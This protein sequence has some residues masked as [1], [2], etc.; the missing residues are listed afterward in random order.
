MKLML[1]EQMRKIDQTAIK[2]YGVPSILLMEHAAYGVFKSIQ[3]MEN[4]QKIVILCGPGNN[5]GDGFALAR[6]LF[7]WSKYKIKI[8]ML[9][10]E[11]KLT[12][13][14][15]I[16]YNINRRIGNTIWHVSDENKTEIFKQ[17]LE[18]DL[19][20]D[21]LFGT[22][23]TRAVSGIYKEVIACANKAECRKVAVDIPSGIDGSTGKIRGI[24]FRADTTITFAAPKLGL[25]QYPAL[26]YIGELVVIDIGIPSAIIEETKTPYYTLELQ[27]LRQ[28]LGKRP[29]RSNKGTYGKVLIIGGQRGM[30]GAVT[31]AAK[32]ALKV[33]AGIVKAAVP[34]CIHNIMEEKLTE[35]MTVP[36]KDHDGHFAKEAAGEIKTLLPKYDVVVIG[37]GMGRS[38]ENIELIIEVLKSEKPC[39]LDADALYFLAELIDIAKIRRAPIIITPHPG[40]MSRIVG[41][42]IE[43]ILENPLEMARC[44]ATQNNIITVLKIERIV[45]AGISGDIYINR[46]GNPGM[47]KGGSG[48]LLTGV[49]AGLLGQG[50]EPIQAAGLGSYIH[51]YAGDLARDKKTEYSFLPMDLYEE[52]DS[53]F[54]L[55]LEG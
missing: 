25:C 27:E 14:G 47:A 8:F 10:S 52:L 49:I 24:A 44:F 29:T 2:E 48:D 1:P 39:I 55:L 21:A 51:A 22:G 32:A 35:V 5:G 54:K 41:K 34:E 33:G 11:E 31:L 38:R 43:E 50:L 19:I 28:L 13:D 17:L 9:A 18:A 30:S 36:L 46:K 23:L 3:E 6:Q 40:E 15:K 26:D 53:V 7:T 16:Y 4:V 12:E 45:I 37:P 20:V 42:S